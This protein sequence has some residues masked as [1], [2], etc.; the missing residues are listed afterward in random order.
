MILITDAYVCK[1]FLF[2]FIIFLLRMIILTLFGAGCKKGKICNSLYFLNEYILLN[3]QM[4][5]YVKHF[6]SLNI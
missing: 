5:M 3:V 2:E 1:A 6:F 4:L